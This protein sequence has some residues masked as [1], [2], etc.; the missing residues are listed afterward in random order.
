MIKSSGF[1]VYPAQVEAVLHQHPAGRG[2]LR[3]RRAGRGPGRAGQGGRRAEGPG[4]GTRRHGAGADRPL[5]RAAD[6]V[7]VPARDRVPARAAQDP[8]RQDRLQGAGGR[9]PRDGD[10]G[11]HERRRAH[12][13]GR[14][15]RTGVPFLF[16]LCGGHISPILVGGQ[17]ARHPRRRHAPR[18]HRRLRRRRGRA[19]DRRARRG[20]GHRRPRPHQHD[21]RAQERAAGAE[22]G[23]CCS[24]ARR[25]RRCRGAARCRTST[26]GRWWR[27]T[28]SAW[29]G[30]SA[31]RDLGAAVDAG[32][33]ASP[34]AACPGRCSSSA[35]STC[36]TTRR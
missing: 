2:G 20:G 31:S 36:C 32:A 21:H 25:R 17:G 19:A 30:S 27:R 4:A 35:R 11:A 34:R 3:D 29:R 28:S 12:R 24:A 1:N 8:R 6:Q 16:T 7:V 22:P 14:C 18:G 5:P 23:A 10:G 13:G 15:A 33:L 26:S 9:A